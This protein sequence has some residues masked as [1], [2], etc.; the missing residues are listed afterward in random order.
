MTNAVEE[1]S[2]KISLL[3]KW[4]ASIGLLLMT[5]VIVVQVFSRYVLNDSPVW[6]EQAALLL[7]IWYVFIAAAAGVREGFHI[8]IAVIA[9]SLPEGPRRWVRL[10]THL[11]VLLFGIAMAVFG[12]Q[13]AAATWE[14]VIPTLGLSRG[15][16][17]VPISISGVLI[18]GFSAEQLFADLR[19]KE[20]VPLWN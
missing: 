16:A 17:Y 9:E 12:A 6:A 20:V 5:A 4:V 15:L 3:S 18:V 19:S 8:R 11:L 2:G 10:L 13:L 1:F 14:H 7:M